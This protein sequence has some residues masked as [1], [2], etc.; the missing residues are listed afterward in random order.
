MGEE[1]RRRFYQN[2]SYSF[3]RKT[4]FLLFVRLIQT[5]FHLI[6]KWIVM[7]SFSSTELSF[8]AIFILFSCKFSF[9]LLRREEIFN[10]LWI[11][12][13]Y[14]WNSRNYIDSKCSPQSPSWQN[15]NFFIKIKLCWS[16]IKDGWRT[17]NWT[18]W[19]HLIGEA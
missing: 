11:F 17:M 8:S 19:S 2:W 5:C 15:W 4:R 6:K 1:V 12:F 14:L 10:V 3:G 16:D 9:E 13:Y 7:L 18:W